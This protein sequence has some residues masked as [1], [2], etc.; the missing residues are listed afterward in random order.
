V[1]FFNQRRSKVKRAT[2]LVLA[3]MLILVLLSGC[4]TK[5]EKKIVARVGDRTIT[6]D[7][8]EVEWRNASR[9]IIQ[10]VPELQRKKELVD[11]MVGDQVV[12]MEA[13]KEGIDNE[14]E[15]DTNFAQQKER[16]ILRVLYQKEIVDK[17][18]PTET[19]LKREYQMMQKEA[20]AWH[21]LVE[22]EEGADEIYKMLKEGADFAQLAREKSIDPTVKDNS[23]DLGFFG[24]GKM[25]PE[26][27]EAVFKMKEGEISKPL[28]TTYG[29]HIIKLVEFKDVEQLPYEEMK[30]QIMPRLSQV[31]RESRM[32]EYFTQLRKKVNF[33]INQE[34]MDILVSK[35]EEMPPDSLG[36]QRPADLLDLNKFTTEEND[37][38]LFSCNK[39][40]TTVKQFAQDFNKIPQRY[41]PRLSEREKIEEMGFQNYLKDILLDVAKEKNLEKNEDFKKEWTV[42]KENEMAVRMKNEVIL[43]GVG[44]SDEE[45]QS[46][47]DRHKDRF[48]IQS[49]V[50]VREILVKTREEAEGVLAQLKRG[51]E[52][53]NL[54]KEKTI[55]SYAKDSGGDL[56]EF[57]RTRYPEL[58]DAAIKLNKGSLD[59]PIKINDRQLGEA[60]AVIKLEDKTEERL[61]P[62]EEVKDKVIRMVR[63]E[64]DNN[65]YQNWVENARARYKIE[66]FDDV[67]ESTVQEK[68]KVPAEQG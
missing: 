41:R 51:A 22:T 50:K 63:Q 13:Y 68:E 23:G 55:R 15:A 12:I 56:G 61:Q 46:Y 19:E 16:L 9:L 3:G 10:G 7:D 32:K 52:F 57:P 25:V 42:V 48:T 64:K 28:Q 26:F 30:N 27:Q 4:G 31:K 53:S 60:Y 62:L 37:M 2:I 65:I 39:G 59:G 49:Q 43:K 33:K 17:S 8:L 58:F 29:W 24:W 11:K 14:V 38:I 66:I 54:A 6:T 47:Y 5:T 40:E 18:E 67:I 36:L 20:H 45:T 1:D 35:K 34:A 21:I 44:I